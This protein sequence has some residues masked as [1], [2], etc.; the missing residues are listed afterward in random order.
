MPV[1]FYAGFDKIHLPSA[2]MLSIRGGR[3]LIIGKVDRNVQEG[4]FPGLIKI[5]IPRGEGWA[6]DFD[7]WVQGESS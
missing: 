2:K 6:H 7:G 4:V 1:P 5:P 3:R